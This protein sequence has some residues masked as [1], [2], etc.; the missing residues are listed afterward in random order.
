MNRTKA[1][2][3][4]LL[5]SVPVMAGTYAS[6]VADDAPSKGFEEIVVTATKRSA[7]MQDVPVAVQAMSGK[8]IKQQ[9]IGNFDDYIR[10]LPNVSSG[11]RGPGQSTVFIRGMAVQPI[12]VMLSGAQGTEPNVA[13]YLDEQPVTAP[14]RNLDV[15]AADLERIEVLPGPQGTL[16]G[17]SSQA[18]TIRLITKKPRLNEFEAGVTGKVSFTRHGEMSE[19]VEGYINVP[20]VE[21]KFAM[22]GVVYSVNNGGY[23]DNVPGT[24]TLDPKVNKNSAVSW[25][26]SNTTYKSATNT[27]LVEKNF[28][29]S[30][31]RGARVGAKYVFNS[32]WDLLVQ[33][34]QQDLGADG[35]FDYDPSV[36]DLE[37]QR[38]YPDKLQ[39]SF[40]LTTWTMHGRLS[41]LDVIYTGGYLD[42]NVTQSIDYTGYNNTGAYI[43]YYTCTYDAVRACLNPIKGFKG[44]QYHNR[45]T[46]ELRFT[47]PEEYRV[48]LTAGVFYDHYK[49]KTLDNYDYVATPDLGFLPNAPIST[50]NNIDPSTRPAGIAFFNDITRTEDQLAFFGELSYD[51]IPEKLTITGGMRY[52]DLSQDFTGSSNFATGPFQNS[53]VDL[54]LGRDYDRSGGHTTAPL[55]SHDAIYKLNISY[56][57]TEDLLLYA[58]YSQGYRPGG[59]NRGGGIPS[60]NPSFPTVSVT[61]GTDNVQNYEAGWKATMFDGSFRFNGDA[62]YINWTDMQISRFDPQNVSILTF[63]ENSADA[64]IKGVEGDFSWLATD[65][66]TVFGAFSYNDAK[67]VK[68]KAQA[69]ELAPVGSQLPL[70][71]KFQANLRARYEWTVG[72]YD[73]YI[74][75][76]IQ[77]ASHSFS[78]LVAADR[79]RQ[80]G[81]TTSD[82]SFG[83]HK[84]KWGAELFIQNI[85]DKR[86]Q[87]FIN[88][89]DDIPRVTTNRP[90][91]IGFKISY[92]Y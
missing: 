42:R 71:P 32:D 55:K 22:R 51:I 35:V 47:T 18:G 1:L 7:K 44:K 25:L 6:A 45:F 39:D 52:Y 33:H 65:H 53:A 74:Q 77:T 67:L 72:N 14:G 34:T 78:S 27:P 70:T 61:Y 62:Y 38:Y 58:T 16:F 85:T 10:F 11:G 81:Y 82:W 57:P 60:A 91:T 40:G 37:V 79:K 50:A 36:G 80:A 15:Y 83:V 90:R 69:I 21:D 64:H 28:N 5:A 46:Q 17:A 31:Y 66:L 54:D 63:I 43:A 12:T 23:I 59:F 89:Q 9:N 48:R 68:A 86:A 92:D 19:S 73:A 76:S 41:M 4:A 2:K 88:Q 8:D 75:G 84:D 20:I 26:P 24:F 49:L 87:L 13:M 30:Y 3:L 29:D 56:H